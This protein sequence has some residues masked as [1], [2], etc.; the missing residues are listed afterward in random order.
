MN[1]KHSFFDCLE[2]YE[3]DRVEMILKYIDVKYPF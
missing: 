1:T 2:P 3:Q